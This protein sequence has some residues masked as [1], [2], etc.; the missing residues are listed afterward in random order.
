MRD[1]F[2]NRKVN[3]RRDPKNDVKYE[4]AEEFREH[5][6]QIAHR[7]GHQRFN[8][9]EFKFLGKKPHR[10]ERK[11]QNEGEPEKHRIEECFLDR[12]ARRSLV[13]ER[14]LK[15]KVDAT[16]EE[17][18]NQNDVGDRRVEIASNF[19]IEQCVKLLHST[20]TSSMCSFEPDLVGVRDLDEHV[21][22]C[23]AALR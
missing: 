16:D 13:H 20:S 8:R 3:K 10:D 17:K 2:E 4:G 18:E 11:D 5:D 15:V 7:C 22:Q 1:L 23:C 19:A 21:L 9:A 6:L 14:N 12:V